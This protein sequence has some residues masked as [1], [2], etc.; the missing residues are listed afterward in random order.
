MASRNKSRL[1]RLYYA[2]LNDTQK[3]FYKGWLDGINTK[4]VGRKAPKAML[5][6]HLAAVV[7]F[8][9]VASGATAEP[10]DYRRVSITAQAAGIAKIAS[11]NLTLFGLE[12]TEAT[13]ANIKS[14]PGF[15]PAL[16][17]V[18]LENATSPIAS[19]T[20][21]SRFSNKDVDLRN[22]RSGSIPFG[23]PGNS[24][25]VDYANRIPVVSMEVSGASYTGARVASIS[26]KPE[27]WPSANASLPTAGSV[28]AKVPDF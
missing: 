10:V 7:P 15:Y 17:V 1:G 12:T 3:A 20:N 19:T 27:I 9:I 24:A 13:L 16:C 2:K 18:T 8:S 25:L 6:R 5:K 14:E 11:S 21:K 23:R 28:T 4:A 26:F 22:T